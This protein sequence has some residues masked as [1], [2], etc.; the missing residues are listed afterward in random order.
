M[1]GKVVG[2]AVDPVTDVVGLLVGG[3]VDVLLGADVGVF[4]S[5]K[6]GN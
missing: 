3:E 5:S 1:V 2:G 6:P 4:L